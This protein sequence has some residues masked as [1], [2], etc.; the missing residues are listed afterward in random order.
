[1]LFPQPIPAMKKF[2]LA[3]FYLGLVSVLPAVPPPEKLLPAD[4]LAMMTVSDFARYTKAMADSAT[5]RFW[6]DNSMTPFREKFMRQLRAEVVEPLEK[7]L[8]VQLKDYADLAQGQVTLAITQNGWEGEPDQRI[9][10]LLLVDAGENAGQ[11]RSRLEALRGRWVEAGEKLRT[12]RIRGSE[13]MV[14]VTSV[15]DILRPLKE[16]FGDGRY[17]AAPEAEG[18]RREIVVGQVGSLLVVG[19]V[20][21]DIEKLLSRLNGG[22]AAGLDGSSGFR[23]AQNAV[24]RESMAYAWLACEPF[25]RIL[26]KQAARAAEQPNSN[27]LMPSP[28]Q[29]LK[30]TGLS[31]LSGLAVGTSEDRGGSSVTFLACVPENGRRGLFNLLS[32]KPKDTAPPR[33]I[34]ADALMYSRW[35]LDLKEAWAALESLLTE[36]SPT[37]SGALQFALQSV[38]GDQNPDFRFREDFL[39]NLGDDIISYEKPPRD[40]TLMGLASPPSVML[41][42]SP[43]AEGLAEALRTLASQVPPSMAELKERDFLGRRIYSIDISAMTG[44]EGEGMSQEYSFAGS[45]GYLV[46]SD[47]NAALEEFL[48]SSESS[49]RSLRETPGLVQTVQAVGGMSTGFLGIENTKD[50]M[51]ILFS[52]LREN[53]DALAVLFDVPSGS[54][55]IAANA[56][57]TFREWVD[58]SLLPEFER[59]AKFFYLTVYTA[60]WTPIGYRVDLLT[61]TP[62]GLGM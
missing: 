39:G 57:K 24:F 22:M 20:V 35:R 7:A 13:F 4:T 43:N 6:N 53:P 33:F 42:G 11:L 28:D 12:Q 54:G 23:A 3:W 25:Y 17:G 46:V 1:M 19:T 26:E 14:L 47:D 36:V 56:G 30:A 5:G 55:R 41:I 9:G 15:E 10:V 32:Q 61:P 31:E 18:G 60:R 16:V 37:M 62:P 8:D 49:G 38:G 48:R 59:V 50:E 44:S 52:A 2:I 45:A 29:I 51:R 21:S 34:P 58:C 40:Q 27:P